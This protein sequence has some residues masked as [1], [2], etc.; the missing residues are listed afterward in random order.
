MNSK[1]VE[2]KIQFFELNA[3][4]IHE[5][6][7]AK[8]RLVHS[9]Y[10]HYTSQESGEKI[11]KSKKRRFTLYQNLNDVK[12]IQSPYERLRKTI[13]NFLKSSS[14][15]E[16]WRDF[17]SKMYGRNALNHFNIYTFSLSIDRHSPV[18]W[19][20]FGKNGKGYCL[21]FQLQPRP[22]SDI[23]GHPTVIT[24][25]HYKAEQYDAMVIRFLD[26]AEQVLQES[27]KFLKKGGRFSNK[28]PLN[29]ELKT[30][31][32]THLVSLLPSLICENFY[33]EKEMRLYIIEEADPNGYLR[34]PNQNR[35][36]IDGI[37]YVFDEFN[38]EDLKEITIGSLIREASIES[39]NKLLK[40]S[41]YN[42][43]NINI[44]ISSY[45]PY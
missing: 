42:L 6:D 22:L 26:L 13:D 2:E 27:K 15:P 38:L 30:H 11:I 14:F 17:L 44:F 8:N 21:G 45:K 9:L 32:T 19:E 25:V 18:L 41:G 7:D 4:K 10:Y 34:V 31:L 40:N 1:R 36:I 29:H 28:H 24:P 3:K 16:F 43:N 39:L 23:R 12:E 5:E 37:E 20:S 35:E 33:D